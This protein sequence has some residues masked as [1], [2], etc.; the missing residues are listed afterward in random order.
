MTAPHRMAW[1]GRVYFGGYDITRICSLDSTY[2]NDT[3]VVALLKRGDM[4]EPSKQAPL[5]WTTLSVHSGPESGA[6]AYMDRH[7]AAWRMCPV[8]H[9]K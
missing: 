2:S 4:F 3:D 1:L 8:K 9:S 6:V 5:A 7:P